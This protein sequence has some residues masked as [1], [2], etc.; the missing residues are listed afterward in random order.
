MIREWRFSLFKRLF[1]QRRPV[2]IDNLSALPYEKSGQSVILLF[3]IEILSIAEAK[4]LIRLCKAGRLFDVQDWIASGK[5]LC[6]P[7]ESKTTPLE[8]ALNSGF[9]S[10]VELLVQNQANQQLKNRALQRALL[11]KRLDLIELLVLHGAEIKSVP[12]IDVLYVW[13]PSIIR[14]FLDQGADF[15]TDSPF[16][17]AFREKIRTAL[18]PW[19]ERKGKYPYHAAHLQEPA[20]RAL[21]HFCFKGDLKWV[22]LLLWAGANPRSSGPMFDDD[23]EDDPDGYTTALDA[24]TY[25]K[26]AQILK[27]LKPDAKR[28]NIDAL[29]V[30]ASRRGNSSMVEHL[31]GLGAKPNDKSNGG[32]SALDDCLRGFRYEAPINFCQTHYGSRSKA[33]KY[34]VAERVKTVELLLEQGA[35]WRPDDNHQ[36]KEVR[37]GLFEFQP[38]VTLELIKQLIKHEA[39][40]QDTLKNLLGTPA[41]K[42]HLTPVSWNFA[43]LGFDVRTKEL[44]EE[45]KRREEAHRQWILR[46]LMRRYDR[47]KIYDE[48]WS[49]PMQHVAKRYGMSDVGFAKICK[50]LQIP[51]PGLGYWAKKAAG[52]PVPKQPALQ[53]A[54]TQDK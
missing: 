32:S 50:K 14:Y 20:D 49:E 42:K 46:D 4:D 22:S 43:R 51:R 16:E 17:A 26:D 10:L 48:I 38:D 33:S 53:E 27:R 2:I 3:V 25:S 24:A 23:D 19:R 7:N 52:K 12:F 29:L 21:R 44:I 47:Q 37:R 9:H 54:H 30:N 11:L 28:D 36:L 5:S 39:C 41:I 8:V 35:L 15:I 34:K 18:S 13:D 45:E 31:L 1:R 40:T 6:L